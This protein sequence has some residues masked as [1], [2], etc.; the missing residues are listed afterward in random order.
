MV[1]PRVELPDPS[2]EA[3]HGG[4]GAGPQ[5]HKPTQFFLVSAEGFRERSREFVSPL[6]DLVNVSCPGVDVHPIGR[7]APRGG[8][9]APNEDPG[10]VKSDHSAGRLVPVCLDPVD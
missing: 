1:A 4:H 10:R 6:M 9:R 8:P 5:R 7:L 2:G 3:P